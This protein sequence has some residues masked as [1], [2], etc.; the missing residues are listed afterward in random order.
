MIKNKNFVLDHPKLTFTKKELCRELFI[1]SKM[2]FWHT[3][4]ITVL[5]VAIFYKM[6]F[7]FLMCDFAVNTFL[8]QTQLSQTNRAML[9]VTEYFAVT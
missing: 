6:Y 4:K 3:I 9:H 1:C 2:T 8:Q 5:T 7:K